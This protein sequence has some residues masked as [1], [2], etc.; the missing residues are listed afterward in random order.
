MPNNCLFIWS[1]W[2]IY[3]AYDYVDFKTCLGMN[4]LVVNQLDKLFLTNDAGTILRE[5]DIEHPAAK[6]IL[7]AS[8]QQEKE[9]GDG[10]NLV[11]VLAGELLANAEQLLR[12]GLSP[13]IIVEGYEMAQKKA[14]EI[15]EGETIPSASL[16]NPRDFNQLKRII[17]AAVASK[18]PGLEEH[19]SDLITK[20]VTISLPAKDE[21]IKSFNIDNVRCIKIIGGSFLGG[22]HV[23][24]GMVLPREPETQLKK[25]T[26][27]KIAVFACPINIGRT[28]T[29]STVLLHDAKEMLA[30]S[31]DEEKNVEA[32][33][34]AIAESGVKVVVA[35]DQ[36]GELALHFLN[37]YGL[38]AMRIQSKFDLRRF[39]RAVGANPMARLGAPTAEEVGYCDVLE[40]V[41]IGGDR[42]TVIRQERE[43]VGAK[44][45]TIILRGNTQNQLDDLERAIEDGINSVRT[46]IVKDSRLLAGAGAVD[47]ELARKLVAYADTTPGLVQYGIREYG[48]AFEVVPRLL[49]TNA[50][51]PLTDAL[52]RLYWAH[53]NQSQPHA[54][55]DVEIS[56]H[57]HQED[58][59]IIDARELGFFDLLAVKRSA[60]QLATEAALTV[61]RVDQIIMAKPAGGPKPRAPGPQ[62]Q[63]D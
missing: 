43:Q 37:R 1:K 35:G 8:Q 16:E 57:N 10:T 40:T 62:D 22:S 54:G 15:L 9:V 49:A 24:N 52:A 51:Q 18:Q 33:I 63:D 34:K 14:L 21:D 41:E 25:V 2:Y 50:G 61:L 6:M 38:A 60:I 28:E 5:L 11:V 44:L 59:G 27:A 17:R 23:V 29:K 20:A 48:K 47:L 30:F 26:N 42:C 31:K 32:Q 46:A 36:I 39:C 58:E 13:S 55:V 7:I 4:K 19:L 53:E 12:L 45:S 56:G 3:F